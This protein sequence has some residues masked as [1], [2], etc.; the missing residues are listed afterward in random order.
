M[1][2]REWMFQILTLQGAPLVD[3]QH[4]DGPRDRHPD[5][6]VHQV[7]EEKEPLRLEYGE[8]KQGEV[9][10]SWS[11]WQPCAAPL[12]H[13]TPRARGCEFFLLNTDHMLHL[14]II[15]HRFHTCY[16]LYLLSCNRRFDKD[17][18]SVSSGLRRLKHLSKAFDEMIGKDDR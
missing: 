12:L 6:A 3:V 18:E 10:D 11:E 9:G 13:P 8:L 14:Y 17:L 1:M 16:C 4:P 7:L 2:R 5:L 15:K